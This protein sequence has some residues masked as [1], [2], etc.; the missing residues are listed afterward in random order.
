VKLSAIVVSCLLAIAAL[1]VNLTH[2]G[3]RGVQ[4]ADCLVARCAGLPGPVGSTS[5]SG[6][7]GVVGIQWVIVAVLVAIVILRD[8]NETE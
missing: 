7:P 5:S 4:G 8:R 3:L 2:G 1:V 6:W